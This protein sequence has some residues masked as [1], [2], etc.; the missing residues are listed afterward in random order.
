MFVGHVLFQ[1]LP[2]PITLFDFEIFEITNFDIQNEYMAFLYYGKTGTSI[3]FKI[4]S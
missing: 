1:H 2:S 3:L 4:L